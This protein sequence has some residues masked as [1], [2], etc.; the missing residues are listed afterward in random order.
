MRTIVLAVIPLAM[1][2]SGECYDNGQDS[3]VC[4]SGGAG[5]EVQ[6]ELY[7]PHAL[8]AA[9]DHFVSLISYFNNLE[10]PTQS[11]RW[12]VHFDRSGS[13]L[14]ITETD[15]VSPAPVIAADGLRSTLVV[16]DNLAQFLRDGLVLDETL[17]DGQA[18]A[19]YRDGYWI[20]V[21]STPRQLLRFDT[22][23]LQLSKTTDS[24]DRRVDKPS[25]ATDPLGDGIAAGW[26]LTE[27]YS[28]VVERFIDGVATTFELAP[29][30]A[31]ERPWASPI[32]M[33]DGAVA[34]VFGAVNDT[35]RIVLRSATDQI[36]DKPVAVPARCPE[37]Q[38]LIGTPEGYLLHCDH[39][40]ILFD[41]TGTVVA[42]QPAPFD[43]R[44]ASGR[45][46]A[47]AIG[48]NNRDIETRDVSI[49]IAEPTVVFEGESHELAGGCS[50][51]RPS[52]SLL[53]ILALQFRSR[54]RRPPRAH[55]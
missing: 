26:R 1:A 12:L 33:R 31:L 37:R 44:L 41:A 18:A 52:A 19:T 42:D 46:A 23:G 13:V 32:A 48:S 6:A 28:V 21:A 29:D 4:P 51:T 43:A 16:R 25:L 9:G 7:E 24:D 8:G 30:P 39:R 34:V 27:T 2:C 47:L 53:V 55:S 15:L 14:Q 38:A 20:A 36:I 5:T 10:S 35:G 54:K 22:N 11:E 45:G 17:L 49:T 50:S 40:F 3:N